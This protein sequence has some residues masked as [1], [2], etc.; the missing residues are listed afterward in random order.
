M[1]RLR[2]PI[3]AATLIGGSVLAACSGGSATPSPTAKALP[4]ASAAAGASASTPAGAGS[5]VAPTTPP[6]ASGAVPSQ[7][8]APTEGAGPSVALP[9][10]ALPSFASDAELAAKFPTTIDGQ[11]VTNVQTILFADILTFAGKT[12]EQVQALAQ[13]LASFGIDL[14]KLSSGSANVTVDDETLQLQ[15]LRAPG[16]D[17]N[18]IV[19]HYNEIAVVFNAALGNAQPST[20]PTLSQADLSGKHITVATDESG[21]KTYL[22]PNGDTLWLLDNMTEAQAGTILT[23]LP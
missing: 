7:G 5:S 4:S 15:A 2:M 1:N 23:S 17:A 8:A 16:G 10:F 6:E 21:D 3:V 22:Y 9:S 11:P 13:S 19:A 18:S 12:P 20:P 14:S